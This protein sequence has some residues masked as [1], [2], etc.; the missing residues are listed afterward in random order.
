MDSDLVIDPVTTRLDEPRAAHR[1]QR[2]GDNEESH[3]E[4]PTGGWRRSKAEYRIPNTE[5]RI[6]KRLPESGRIE[7]D[8]AKQDVELTKYKP[9]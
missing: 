3:P 5:I 7:K 1:F 2:A 6:T 4:I 9:S 8:G